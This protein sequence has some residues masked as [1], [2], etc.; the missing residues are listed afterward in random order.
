VE[1]NRQS[2]CI[3]DLVVLNQQWHFMNVQLSLHLTEVLQSNIL[4]HSVLSGGD[5]AQAY[6]VETQNQ[7]LLVKVQDGPNALEMLIAENS[8]LKAIAATH[9]IR[10]PEVMYCGRFNA[11]AVLV[12]EYIPTKQPVAADLERFGH[13]LA[14]LHQT[15]HHQFGWKNENF[16]GRLPQKNSFCEDWTTYYLV[17]RLLPQFSMAH[18]A[19]F[20]SASEIPDENKISKVLEKLCIDVRPSLLHGDLWN[21]NYLIAENGD[22]YLIDPSVYFGHYE[23]DLAMSR[24]FGGFGNRFYM[25]YAETIPDADGAEARNE[26]Y[27]LYYLLVHLNMFGTSYAPAVKTITRHYF[28]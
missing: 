26:I 13:Q 14:Q 8:G 24:L 19:G 2:P 1:K 18:D 23:I 4:R 17:N 15:T 7:Q 27:Q 3:D 25:A 12:M 22:P 20:L 6:L 28:G 10:T 5:I 16:I 11:S 21:G 9:T